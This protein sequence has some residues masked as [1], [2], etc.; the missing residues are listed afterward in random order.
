MVWCG[1]VSHVMIASVLPTVVALIML[2][3]TAISE[4]LVAVWTYRTTGSTEPPSST[5]HPTSGSVVTDSL[6]IKIGNT[7]K[8]V[9]TSTT[10]IL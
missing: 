2:S 3:I 5:L 4:S 6:D 1:L 8:T 7:V 9:T 10:T